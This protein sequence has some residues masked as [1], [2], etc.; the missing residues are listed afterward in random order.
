M[1]FTD[2]RRPTFVV[3]WSAS[4]VTSEKEKREKSGIW[5]WK[6]KRWK[7]AAE[8]FEHCEVKKLFVE[9]DHR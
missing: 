4:A 5:D 9:E 1:P 3:G 7:R 6:R 2:G 8:P